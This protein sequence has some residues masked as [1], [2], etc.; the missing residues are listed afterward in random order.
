MKEKEKGRSGTDE[1][2]E[3]R[4]QRAEEGKEGGAAVSADGIAL[5]RRRS[6][7]AHTIQDET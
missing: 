5:G 1:W 2:K 6:S 7:S 3:G 4:L